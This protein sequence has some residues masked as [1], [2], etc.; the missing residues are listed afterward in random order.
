MLRKK[1]SRP[2][3]CAIIVAAGNA[4]RM[5]GV[6]KQLVEIGGTPV[7]IRSILAFEH[8]SLVDEIIVVSKKES[9]PELNRQVKN[10]AADKVC[11][12]V[13]GGSTRQESVFQGISCLHEDCR[14]VAI[15]DGARPLVLTG[16][17]DACIEDA[18]QHGAALLGVR[19]KDTIKAVDERRFIENTVDREKLFLA[20]TP[21]IFELGLYKQA[22]NRAAHAATSYTDDCQLV[23]AAGYKVY[24]SPG[25]YSNI[26]I[27]TPDDLFFAEAL[28]GQMGERL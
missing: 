25:H 19:V 22:M 24:V 12:I 20:Q 27:T 15:H 21:Q 13:A 1:K 26:K 7:I 16:A 2:F 6:D 28:L 10:Y 23:E 9:I 14:Y 3:V 4:S 5:D 18:V 8:S 17:I 11:C